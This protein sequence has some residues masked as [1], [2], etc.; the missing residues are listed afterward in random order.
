MNPFHCSIKKAQEIKIS[1]SDWAE[2]RKYFDIAVNE[3]LI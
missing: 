2:L 1:N 3:H